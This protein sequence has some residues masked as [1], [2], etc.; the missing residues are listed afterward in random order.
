MSLFKWCALTALLLA[1]AKVLYNHSYSWW[2]CLI[3]LVVY[4]I[5][6]AMI[7]WVEVTRYLDENR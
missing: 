6:M 3:P 7:I 4:L 5:I 2:V 1:V